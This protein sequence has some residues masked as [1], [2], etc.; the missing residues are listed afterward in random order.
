MERQ[1]GTEAV[2]RKQ[3]TVGAALTTLV[4][5]I[6]LCSASAK[7]VHVPAIVSNLAAVGITDNKLVFVATLEALSALLFLIART[8]SAGLLLVSAFLGGAIATHLQHSESI[9]QPSIVLGLSWLAV[10]LQYREELMWSFRRRR[11][12]TGL[13][14]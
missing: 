7:F 4:G 9:A 2:S 1:T 8:R 10:W 14:N 5:I 3:R 11:S 12:A 6:L 13:E